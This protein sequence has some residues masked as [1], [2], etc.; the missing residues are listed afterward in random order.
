MI[1]L[2]I[3]EIYVLTLQTE[4]VWVMVRQWHNDFYCSFNLKKI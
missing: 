3:R 1:K 2:I 4:T